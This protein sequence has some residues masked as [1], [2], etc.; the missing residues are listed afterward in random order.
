[1]SVR[2]AVDEFAGLE[3]SESGVMKYTGMA[4]EKVKEPGETLKK[5]D[6]RT[7]RTELNAP[8]ADAGRLGKN[9]EKT[10]WILPEPAISSTS[11]RV[12]IWE[13]RPLKVLA[14]FP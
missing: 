9:P 13:K 6:T 12:K 11:P 5:R 4:G 3:E 1:L 8:A 14:N 7:A 2:R 10:C